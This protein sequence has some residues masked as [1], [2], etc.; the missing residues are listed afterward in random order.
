MVEWEVVIWSL[1]DLPPTHILWGRGSLR[2][3]SLRNT[4]KNQWAIARGGQDSERFDGKDRNLFISI[5]LMQAQD[6]ARGR[7]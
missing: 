7:C 5:L 3:R 1:L 4:V 6:L 2:N